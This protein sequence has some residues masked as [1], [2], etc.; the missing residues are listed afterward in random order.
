[1][2]LATWKAVLAEQ[3]RCPFTKQPMRVDQLTVLTSLNLERFQD[4]IM[5]Q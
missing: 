2:G 4:R 3:A 5:Q 1:M